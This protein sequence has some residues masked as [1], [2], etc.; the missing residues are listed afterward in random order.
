MDRRNPEPVD[1]SATAIRTTGT[2]RPP[3]RLAL[4]GGV[5]ETAGRQGTSDPSR[6]ELLGARLMPLPTKGIDGVLHYTC[7]RD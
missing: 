3:G 2:S 5:G 6:V 4:S 1:V 7:G